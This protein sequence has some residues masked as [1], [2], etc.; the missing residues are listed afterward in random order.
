MNRNAVSGIVVIAALAVCVVGWRVL[1]S[2]QD[3]QRVVDAEASEHIERARRWLH[4]YSVDLT[5]TALL[6]DQLFEHGVDIDVEEPDALADAAADEYQEEHEAA[7]DA[8]QPMDWEQGPQDARANYGNIARQIREGIEGRTAL[9]DANP[10]FLQQALSAVREALAVTHG[11]ADARSHTEANRLKGVIQFHLGLAE[12]MHADAVRRQAD[13]HRR[14]LTAYATD[15]SSLQSAQT[16]VADCG[17]DAQIQG[18]HAKV[19]ESETSLRDQRTAVASLDGSIREI[20]NQIS[21]AQS[22]AD[23]ARAALDKL[24]ADGID[25]SDPN[26]PDTFATAFAD[27]DRAYRQAVR[28]V[29]SLRA[30]SI[31]HAELQRPGDY[32]DADYVEN[33]SRT[34]LTFEHG[35]IHYENER[36]VLAATIEVQE[37]AIEGLRSAIARLDGMKATYQSEQDRAARQIPDAL[38]AAQETFD[39]LN[40]IES[41]AYAIE[42][43]ALSLLDQ[44]ARASKQAAGFAAD[45][46]NDARERAEALPAGARDRSPFAKREQDRWIG[47]HVAAQVADARLARA[48]IYHQ[49]FDAY[50]QNA[51]LLTKVAEPLQLKEADAESEQNKATEAHDAGVEEIN[52]AV[53]QLKK[54]H[55][56]ADRH[57][58][59]V[60][61]EAGAAYMM[62]LFGHP[63]YVDD[64]IDAYRNAIQG[65]EDD[66]KAQLFVDRSDRLEN[67]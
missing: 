65:R 40:R 27:H 62:A 6:R 38:T 61:Q 59:F 11:D 10:E 3:P 32:L 22:R 29:Q 24:K 26:G 50:T 33:G 46:I 53:A 43:E 14:Q 45:A 63:S 35:L 56:D 5:R 64:A 15:V 39:E 23:E 8:Y 34:D 60:A 36:N 20:E 28:D 58:T 13:P 54:A 55:R 30:G 67:M 25:F 7:W 52:T 41:E 19:A 12:W 48:W 66:P 17:L 21:V 47:G 57:W 31:P 37:Q 49:Q 2:I 51:A 4:R 44:S 42:E 9:V 16:L 18:L 1:P